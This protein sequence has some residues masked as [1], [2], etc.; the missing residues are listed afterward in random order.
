MD[1][2]QALVKFWQGTGEA[3]L[4]AGPFFE[5]AHAGAAG[6]TQERVGLVAAWTAPNQLGPLRRPRTFL[7]AGLHLRDPNREGEL[8]LVA[9]VGFSLDSR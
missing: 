6:I 5:V 2:M 1:S 7:Q 3:A 4:W 8:F 9:G